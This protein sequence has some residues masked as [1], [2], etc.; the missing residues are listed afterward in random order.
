MA[1]NHAAVL[2]AT[3]LAGCATPQER[4]RTVRVE[5]PVA[6]ECPRPTLPAR[7]PLPLADVPPGA[8]SDAIARAALASLHACTG[9]AEQLEAI[10]GR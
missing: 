2:L 5:V 8:G 4:V 10:N 9:Y 1:H 3:L 7:P 6:V